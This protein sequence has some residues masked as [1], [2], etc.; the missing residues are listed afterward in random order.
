MT[1]VMLLLFVALFVGLFALGTGWFRKGEGRVMRERLVALAQAAQRTPREDLALLRDEL[2]S[3]I[4]AFNRLLSRFTRVSRLHKYLR[5]ANVQMRP[6]KFLLF[7]VSLAAVAG[8]ATGLLRISSWLPLAA[9]ALGVALPFLYVAQRR[10]ARFYRFATR[11]PDAIDVLV[12]AVR[13][14][15]SLAGAIEIIAQ[16]LAEPIAGEFRKVFEEQKFGM[17]LRDALL[18]L[19][20]RVPLLDV[21]FFVT[22]VLLQRESGGNLAEILEKL[23]YLIRERF[24]LLRQL[25]VYTAHARLTMLILMGL[26]IGWVVLVSIANPDYLRPLYTDLLGQKMI[27]AAVVMQFIGYLLIRKIA[28]IRA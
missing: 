28:H 17:P 7:T 12:R 4:P 22:A 18:N 25:R 10:K 23:A 26:P 14:G 15:H 1:L 5:Q 27:A 9:A 16:E 24:K 20:E 8:L 21:K 2:L 6:G 19:T 11:L 13:A 3:A